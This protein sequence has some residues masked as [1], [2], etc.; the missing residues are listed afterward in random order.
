MN[1]E[2]Y[3]EALV[4]TLKEA[5]DRTVL[6]HD[7]VATTAADLL[8]STYRYARALDGLGIGRGDLVALH[9]P[10]SPD[11]LAVRYA[12]HL[13]GA[14]TMYLPA[15]PEA[16]QRAALLEFIAPDLLIAFPETAHLLPLAATVRVAVVGSDVPGARLRL[17]RRAYGARRPRCPAGPAPTTSP[18]SSPRAVPPASRRA[19]SGRSRPTPPPSP[20]PSTPHGGSSPTAPWPT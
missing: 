15:L 3:L 17:D 19:A 2:I 9:A 11:A 13:V 14:A 4:A 1:G 10:N 5:G 20:R 18:S 8:A 6:E 16:Q 7:G 12:A